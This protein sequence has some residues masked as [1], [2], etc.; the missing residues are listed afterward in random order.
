MEVG[1][2][3]ATEDTGLDIVADMLG[4]DVTDSAEDSGTGTTENTTTNAEKGRRQKSCWSLMNKK[5]F[6]C[7]E[8]VFNRKAI[9]LDWDHQL[10]VDAFITNKKT[11]KQT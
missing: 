6:S 5:Y 2:T 7:D 8:F 10:T 3:E 11:N 9:K 1:D 4:A